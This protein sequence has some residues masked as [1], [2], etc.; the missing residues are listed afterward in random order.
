MGRERRAS[1]GCGPG[2]WARVR[3]ARAYQCGCARGGC[4]P[5]RVARGVGVAN[6]ALDIVLAGV[7][8]AGAAHSFLFADLAGFTALTEAH[9]DELAA[10]LVDAFCAQVRAVLPDYDAEEVKAIG[11]ALMLRTSTAHAGV[12]LALRLVEELGGRHGFPA[13]RV[14]LHTGP[15]VARGRGWLRAAVNV[16]AGV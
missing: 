11:D 13:L 1:G 4:V 3:A 12:R 10:D 8:N 16:A 14:G 7:E 6:L 15:A 2:V 5:A 9:G